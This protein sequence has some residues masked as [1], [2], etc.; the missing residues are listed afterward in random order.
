MKYYCLAVLTAAI[1]CGD[2]KNDTI[3]KEVADISNYNIIIA[4]DLSNRINPHIHPK[5]IHD[6]VIIND[7]YEQIPTFIKTGNR[8][9][10]QMDVFTFDFIN[11]GAINKISVNQNNIKVDFSQFGTRQLERSDY[12]RKG[13]TKDIA[14]AKESIAEIYKYAINNPSGADIYNYLNATVNNVLV[15]E[16]FTITEITSYLDART[17]TKNII[18]LFTDGYI[19]NVT[20]GAGFQFTGSTVRK[21]RENFNKS[22]IKNL[23][24][25]IAAHPQYQINPLTNKNLEHARI[26]VVEMI[27][28]SLDENGVATAHPTDFVI[29]RAV[30]EH[31]FKQSN[32]LDYEFINAQNTSEQ[33]L[34]HI[35]KFIAKQAGHKN[36]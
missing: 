29:M 9:S 21:I 23:N 2:E 25:F 5:P 6:T 1:S 16:D 7:V 26:I 27:D 4:P 30:W 15:P 12:I 36:N 20:K 32:V 22:E 3:Q 18:I 34:T 33:T 11:G 28:R 13:L 8:Q 31:W 24:H 14:S 10:Q 35:K 17:S 19:E